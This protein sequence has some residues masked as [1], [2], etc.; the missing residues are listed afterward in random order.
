[1]L[2]LLPLNVLDAMS[3][4]AILSF[5]TYPDQDTYQY[6]PQGFNTN[7]ISHVYNI[8]ITYPTV[9]TKC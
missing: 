5:L 9:W 8:R 1:M 2:V 3:L 4:S 7:A 6:V